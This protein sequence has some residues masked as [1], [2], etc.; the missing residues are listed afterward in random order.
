MPHVGETTLLAL[1]LLAFAA[2]GRLSLFAF[3]PLPFFALLPVFALPFLAVF[4]KL[5]LPV[6]VLLGSAYG[7]DV[8]AEMR[9]PTPFPDADL[10]LINAVIVVLLGG[11][12]RSGL[13][14]RIAGGQLAEGFFCLLLGEGRGWFFLITLERDNRL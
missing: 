6:F 1:F 8:V 11:L 9:T 5:L 3:L 7:T 10:S 4:F 13:A 12:G 2:D 14:E